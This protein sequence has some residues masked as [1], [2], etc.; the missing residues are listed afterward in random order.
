[1]PCPT[2]GEDLFNEELK[3]GACAPCHQADY[4]FLGV[5]FSWQSW[6][7][8]RVRWPKVWLQDRSMTVYHADTFFR[9]GEHGG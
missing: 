2:C 4:E 3:W 5:L 9:W 1:M 8:L 6:P 7:R